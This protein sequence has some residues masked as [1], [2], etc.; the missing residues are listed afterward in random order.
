M[1]IFR[2]N[3]KYRLTG[4]ITIPE[5]I[6]M[7]ITAIV[8]SCIFFSVIL[9]L[10]LFPYTQ[11]TIFKGVIYPKDGIVY[12][13]ANHTGTIKNFIKKDGDKVHANEPILFIDSSIVTNSSSNDKETYM[14]LIENLMY[15]NNLYTK[16]KISELESQKKIMGE[17]LLYIYSD[18]SHLEREKNFLSESINNER[19]S[20]KKLESAYH[21]KYISEIDLNN[22]RSKI[23]SKLL[24]I[25]SIELSLSEK[26]TNI[27]S[28][29][30][31]ISEI[32]ININ[33]LKIDNSKNKI[34]NLIQ[35]NQYKSGSESIITATSD[36]NISDIR[37]HD[38]DSVNIG[39]TILSIL[40]D[41]KNYN[42]VTFVSLHDI[43]KIKKNVNVSVMYQSY[44]YQIYGVDYGI[45]VDI[46]T[47]PLS[48]NDIYKFYG[49]KTD[50]PSYKL[51]IKLTRHNKKFQQIPL[52]AAD[53]SIPMEKRKLIKWLI[54]F[55]N[56]NIE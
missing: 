5:L 48:S 43:G 12:I 20:Y 36:G 21:K 30:E 55:F 54:P 10:F 22:A 17:K 50:G 37:K 28:I 16:N 4:R 45:I 13:N 51:V 18:I 24:Q 1:T 29:K 7:R 8:F 41:N 56:K 19:S 38:G 46:S 34:Q 27:K 26:K 39:D 2:E 52:M 42:I 47:S 49:I 44:P 11:R 32:N 6:S 40:P 23:E 3:Y 9:F 33:Q 25:N 15:N 14:R 35:I 31:N 53:I